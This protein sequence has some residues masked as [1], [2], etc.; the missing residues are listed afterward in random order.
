MPKEQHKKSLL[1]TGANGQVGTL[2]QKTVWRLT[3]D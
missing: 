2:L 3:H 1:I